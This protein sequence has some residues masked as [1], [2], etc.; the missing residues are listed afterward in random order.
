MVYGNFGDLPPL[1]TTFGFF[2]L[3]G[4]KMLLYAIS[5]IMGYAALGKQI[6]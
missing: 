1:F 6:L 4:Q 5:C 3:T 2:F